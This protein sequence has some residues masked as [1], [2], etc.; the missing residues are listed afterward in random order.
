[1]ALT[2][3]KVV[4]AALILTGS[5]VIT[6]AEY[7]AATKK[8]AAAVAATYEMSYKEMFELPVDWKFCT[9][10]TEL[11]PSE[12]DPEF[13][14]D[15]Q[16]VVPTNIIRPLAVVDESDDDIEY[17]W[18]SE[19]LV[20]AETEYDVILANE[21]TLFLKYMYVRT[22]ESKWPAW[23]A[24]LVVINLAL[25]LCEPLKQK[26]AKINQL[27]RMFEKALILAVQANALSDVDVS[28]YNV[29]LDRGNT[30]VLSAATIEEVTKQRIVARG[31]RLYVGTNYIYYGADSDE[32]ASASMVEGLTDSINSNQKNR[33]VTINAS[34]GYGWYCYPARLGVSVMYTDGVLG[35]FED[36]ETVS[37]TNA[38]GL[39]E[40]YYCYR[41][42]NEPL[43]SIDVEITD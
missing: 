17:K 35:G 11:V 29:A 20:D 32:S 27:E 19:L 8:S 6:A 9:T 36:P 4:N 10:R 24:K 41:T 37:V 5:K 23:F 15:Y 39:T 3:L 7:A 1:M 14:Y 38:I 21:E 31:E 43:A 12:I 33:E 34:S 42:T 26:S 2:E 18:R 28:D 30:D 22:D 13:G 40:N 25:Y 16:F